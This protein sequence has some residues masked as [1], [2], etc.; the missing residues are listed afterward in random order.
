[1]L[2]V[3]GLP[4]DPVL[5]GDALGTKDGTNSGALTLRPMKAD[6][7][8]V[9]PWASTSSSSQ[10]SGAE[11]LWS[12][13]SSNYS[14]RRTESSNTQNTF[15]FPLTAPDNRVCVCVRVQKSE[16]IYSMSLLLFRSHSA[17]TV[18]SL[19]LL[20]ARALHRSLCE[21]RYNGAAPLIT[22]T[23]PIA[24]TF[25]ELFTVITEDLLT[26]YLTQ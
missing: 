14:H 17:D 9:S 3:R 25:N 1:M 12:I 10:L 23:K 24:L 22:T 26:L 5:C 16:R 15:T 8:S 11:S 18:S 13:A 21:A 19:R 4:W 20:P 2:W 6:W 7:S